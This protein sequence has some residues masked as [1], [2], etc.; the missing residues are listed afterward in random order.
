MKGW[1]KTKDAQ[2]YAGGI[3]KKTLMAWERAGLRTYRPRNGRQK[4]YK[5][6]DID[7]FMEKYPADAGTEINA[8]VEAIL[9]GMEG[10]E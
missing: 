4:F 9:A 7:R 8:T 1:L 2:K 3:S 10:R 5:P 6:A